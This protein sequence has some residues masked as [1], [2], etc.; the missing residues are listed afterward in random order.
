MRPKDHSDSGPRAAG[1]PAGPR[2]A[3]DP[4][5]WERCIEH[6][7][8]E[9]R[10]FAEQHFGGHHR[11]VLLIGGAGFDP[12][13]LTVPRLLA[14]VCGDRLEGMFLRERRTG[15]D[16]SL[17]ARAEVNAENLRT[18]VPDCSIRD[19]PVFEPDG[20]VSVG[21]N[22]VEA[23][24][25]IDLARF[26]DVV[27]DF[28]A[29]SIGSSFPLTRLM[30]EGIEARGPLVNLHAMVTAS[31][32]TDDQ[33]V[34]MPSSVVGPVHGFPGRWGIDE[35]SR[36]AKLWMPQLRFNQGPILERVYDYVLPD[37]VVPVLPFPALD[38]RVGDRLIDHYASEFDGRWQVDA[39]SIV[40]ADEK[41]P[42]DF[43]R[44]VLRIHDRRNP[45]FSST[46]GSLLV[47]SPMG[48]KVLALGAMMAATE[49]DLPVVYVEALGYSAGFAEGLDTGYSDTD[50]VHVWLL[51][52]AYSELP[53]E[54]RS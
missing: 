52:E 54:H 26:T 5:R 51:G 35:T 46:T 39:R 25:A 47:L 28:S 8:T 21:R 16:A 14:S 17:L 24:A 22:M 38:P 33:I 34:P 30:L 40:Y 32:T 13:S 43:Y 50:I 20:A 12:R 31:P 3:G 44:T 49:R 9:V 18:L 2:A 19:I 48:S 36:A 23:A 10:E 4:P 11:R 27:V 42:L 53:R 29:L 15:P 37:D 1:T 6:R 7:G 45:V 41:N